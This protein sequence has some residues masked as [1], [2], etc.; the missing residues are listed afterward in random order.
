[1]ERTPYLRYLKECLQ[2]AEDCQVFESDALAH[3]ATCLDP[4]I[5]SELSQVCCSSSVTISFAQ[6]KYSYLYCHL[7]CVFLQCLLARLLM[8]GGQWHRTD[9]L[10]NCMPRDLMPKKE[11]ASHPPS[12]GQGQE[13]EQEQ[14][15]TD[16]STAEVE[17][18]LQEALTGLAQ[19]GLLQ[20]LGE[21]HRFS[22][23]WSALSDCLFA[24]E[25][26]RVHHSIKKSRAQGY[27][28]PCC[29]CHG[30]LGCRSHII[31]KSCIEYV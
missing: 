29:C 12:E 27:C 22:E 17:A 8:R 30:C 31:Y 7:P 2:H 11:A 16:T 26:R 15:T 19:A 5:L 21:A 13:Q 24:D 6:C 10:L 1:M 9:R 14:G 4:N 3:R 23:A 28:M 20:R 18:A 25:L